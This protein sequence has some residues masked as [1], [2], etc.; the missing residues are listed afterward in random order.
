MFW[1]FVLTACVASAAAYLGLLMLRPAVSL[2]AWGNIAVAAVV[3]TGL[4]FFLTRA[5]DERLLVEPPPD[6]RPIE[7]L[8]GDYV[9]S[10]SC[11]SCHPGEHASWSASYHST[12]TRVATPESVVGAFDNH[13]V[14]AAGREY[15]LERVGEEFFVELD[16]DLLESGG[17]ES[18]EPDPAGSSAAAYAGLPESP[19]RL[20]VKRTRRK[21]L[22]TT[23]S[24][25]IQFCW[26]ESGHSRGL[27]QLPLAW[28]IHEQRWVA[29]NSTFVFPPHEPEETNIGRWN[30]I[31]IRCH[32][33]DA[34]PELMGPSEMYSEAS[35]FGISCEACHGPGREH[36]EYYRFP[37]K[38]YSSAVGG[39]EESSIKD[40]TDLLHPVDSHVCAQCHSFSM[41]KTRELKEAW[42]KSGFTYRPGDDLSVTRFIGQVTDADKLKIMKEIDPYVDVGHFWPDG[43]IRVAGREYNGLLESPCFQRAEGEHK[44][45][46]FSCHLMHRQDDD[47]RPVKEWA[48]DQLKPGMD[49]NQACLQCH[50]DVGRKLTAHTHHAA[51]SSGSVCYNCHMPYTTYALMGAIRSHQVD[52]PDVHI[53]QT[54]G[55]PNACNQ[56]H[57][58]KTLLWTAERLEEWYSQP[59]PTLNRE[60]TE[61]AASVLWLLR[62]DAGQRALA[63]WSLGWDSAREAS[64]TGWLPPF[65]GQLM[66]DPYDTVRFIAHKGLRKNPGFEDFEWDY[67]APLEQRAAAFRERYNRWKESPDSILP[68]NSEL[69]IGSDGR[70]E[71]DR[72]N[73]FLRRRDNRAMF[74][75]E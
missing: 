45:S 58:D 18:S 40:P 63:A 37:G 70:V 42:K 32:A 30:E 49:G 13:T 22:M 6:N 27:E 23:G 64:G 36:V 61:V 1:E 53:T 7:R 33:T 20:P 3:G 50:E 54:T 59:R 46:C 25:H 44:M 31:C 55:R 29:R 4:T 48:N 19:E 24:H 73:D 39:G 52:S 47:P 60:Q 71:S 75:M 16:A 28:L 5:A 57:L 12:M 41:E 62:G 15:R 9:G 34:R 72:F 65:L 11:R 26:L 2:S 74:L 8:R 51:D 14:V 35:E 66:L 10:Q 69:L 67:T 17:V 21:V 56:C 68:E 38:R 43:M